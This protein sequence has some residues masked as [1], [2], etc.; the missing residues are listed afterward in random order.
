MQPAHEEAV[1][2]D[3]LAG[4]L[5]VDVRRWLRVAGRLE[6]RAVAGDERQ[7]LGARVQAMTT[8]RLVD[9]VGRDL[10]AAPLGARQARRD[11][12]RTQPGMTKRERHD[13]LLDDR[14][15]LVGHLADGA[16]AA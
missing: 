1:D 13:A 4:A 7:A 16:P 5:A 8:Q 9:P 15:E 14:R 3:E 6:R 11:P 10:Q 2:P 12:L